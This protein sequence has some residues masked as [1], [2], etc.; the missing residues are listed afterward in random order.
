MDWNRFDPDYREWWDTSEEESHKE[1]LEEWGR[2]KMAYLGSAARRALH[3]ALIGE[4]VRQGHRGKLN[5]NVVYDED[6]TTT[7]GY[8]DYEVT[9]SS[10][11]GDVRITEDT[12]L[13]IAV[14]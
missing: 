5:E 14:G 4:V 6:R 2:R 12:R 8:V 3:R 9:S 1:M 11:A 10:P 13:V 7:N